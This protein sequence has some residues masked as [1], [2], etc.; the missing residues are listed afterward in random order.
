MTAEL[1][2]PTP[3]KSLSPNARSHF[4]AKARQV[5]LYRTAVKVLFMSKFGTSFR[6]R[7][8]SA[9]VRITW[10]NRR[11]AF[12]DRDNAL[13]SLKA[14]FDGLTDAGLFDDDRGLTHEPIVF[15]WDPKKPPRV[16]LS[17]SPM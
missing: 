15:R 2:I 1:E 5:K 17:I 6:P 12:P 7:W 4:Q 16:E 14:A 11:L 10:W 8:R 9:R 13:A 3:H